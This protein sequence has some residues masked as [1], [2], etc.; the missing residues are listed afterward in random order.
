MPRFA[1]IVPDVLRSVYAYHPAC[2]R[3][4]LF[5]R[6]APVERQPFAIR[7]NEAEVALIKAA[8]DE[9]A[10]P[11][12]SWARSVLMRVARKRAERLEAA[13]RERTTA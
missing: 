1:T 6:E 11:A 12:R 5:R 8:A 13:S 7:L 10:M 9:H 4:T 3:L 2:T